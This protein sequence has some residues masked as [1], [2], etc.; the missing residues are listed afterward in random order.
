MLKL[1]DRVKQSSIT[2][3][4]GDIVLYDTYS[5]F[6]SFAAAIGDGNSTYYTIENNGNYE[7]GIGTYQ[8][9]G[10]I[11]SRDLVLRSSNNNNKILLDG[12]SIVFCT[13]PADYAYFLNNE[14]YASGQQPNY[15]GIAFPNGTIQYTAVNG[16]GVANQIPY[17]E[18]E[19]TLSSNNGLTFDNSTYTLN[20]SGVA[21]F[22]SDVTVKG[23]FT[24]F[25]TQTVVNTEISN[26]QIEQSTLVDTIFYRT[27][28]GCFFHAYVDN[29]YDNI[30]SLYSTNEIDTHWKLG[31]KPYTPSFVSSPVFGYVEGSN[32]HA[33]IY[34]TSQNYAKINFTNGFWVNHRNIDV[35]NASKTNGASIYN[36]TATATAFTVK[37]A[38]AQS[39]NL[40]EWETYTSTVVASIDI[41]G[42]LSCSSI[43]FNANNSTQTKAYT[44]NYRNISTSNNILITDDVVFVDTNSGNIDLALPSAVNNGGKKIVIKRKSGNHELI[45]IPYL[46]EKID[47]AI[48]FSLNYNNQS[49]TLV[50]DNSNWYII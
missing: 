33:G 19:T 22:D 16:S 29:N 17:W 2:V 50:S 5:G 36:Q 24:V 15:Q 7:I 8:S 6:T 44:E 9:N 13:Y 3:G 27:S 23:D 14:G 42:M 47:N 30:I 28:A 35:F 32:G 40:Q 4:D 39:A 38:A 1:A 45:I 12:V 41:N 18:N 31:L 11:L 10:N 34:A 46:S 43:R 21:I 26:T 37:A 25:G 20:V 48:S 49:I